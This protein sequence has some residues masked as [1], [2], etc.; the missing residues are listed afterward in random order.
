KKAFLLRDN[1][2]RPEAVE[3][4]HVEVMGTNSIRIL[5]RLNQ[6]VHEGWK[7]PKASPFGDGNAGKRI[8]KAI[9]HLLAITAL[10]RSASLTPAKQFEGKG[11]DRKTRRRRWG[12]TISRRTRCSYRLATS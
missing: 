7:P 8:V 9:Q 11:L 4:G 10:D 2:E 5:R 3:S 12:P 1:T 6:F